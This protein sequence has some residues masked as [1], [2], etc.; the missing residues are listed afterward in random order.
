MK[1][2]PARKTIS[3]GPKKRGKSNTAHIRMRVVKISSFNNNLLPSTA[4]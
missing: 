4:S 3:K 1:K 2:I